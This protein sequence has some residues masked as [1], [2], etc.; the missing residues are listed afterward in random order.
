VKL[1]RAK[2]FGSTDLA[3]DL[4]GADPIAAIAG[5]FADWWNRRFQRAL[6]NTLA[7]AMGAPACR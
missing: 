4:A 1:L 6:L 7:G 3:G 2:A 5:R